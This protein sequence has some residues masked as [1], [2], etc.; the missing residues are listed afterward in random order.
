MFAWLKD[1]TARKYCQ[2]GEET[3][4]GA[5]AHLLR[6]CGKTIVADFGVSFS[7]NGEFQIQ[8]TPAGNFLTGEDVDLI[9][10]THAHLDHI[11]AVVRLIK[12]HP[13]ASII[14]SRK[15]LEALRVMLKDS[16]KIMTHERTKAILAGLPDPGMVFES[17]DLYAFLDRAQSQDGVLV[18]EEDGWYDFDSGWDGWSFGIFDSGHDTGAKSFLIIPPDRKPI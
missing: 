5:T 15:A 14:V 1:S 6:V 9:I 7:R 11:G 13:E 4:I 3:G 18:V 12:E 16:L 2:L 17:E 8:S 10:V